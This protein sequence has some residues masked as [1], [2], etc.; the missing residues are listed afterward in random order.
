[1]NFLAFFGSYSF[2]VRESLV[3]VLVAFS[4]YLLL[5]AGIFALPQIGLM[6]VG[7]YTASLCSQG[8][9]TPLLVDVLIGGIAAV[10]VALLLA[11][12]LTR[13]SGIYLAI[14]TIGFGEVVRLIAQNLPLTG[15]PL[16]LVGVDLSINDVEIVGVVVVAVVV[17]ARL[18]RSR[19]GLAMTAMRMDGITA[20]HQGIDVRRYRIILFGGAGFL[21]GIGGGLHAHLTGLIQ[22]DE[23]TFTL[24][25]QIVTVTVIGGMT[26]VAGPLIGAVIIFSLPQVLQPIAP[27]RALIDGAILIVVMAFAPLGIAELL[28]RALGRIRLFRRRAGAPSSGDSQWLRRQEGLSLDVS[29]ISKRFGGLAALSDVTLDVEPGR[30]LGLIGPN[31]SGKTTLLNV[32]S[33]VYV[34]DQG[35]GSLGTADLSRQ[36]GRPTLI[37]REGMSRT[38]QAIRLINGATVRENVRLG[39]YGRSRSAVLPTIL[40]LPSARREEARVDQEIDDCLGALGLLDVANESATALPYGT[41][42]KV[43]IAR[44]LASRP[45]VLLLDEPTAGMTPEERDEIFGLVKTVSGYGIAVVVIEHDVASMTNTC[46]HLVVLDFGR[47]IAQGAPREVI[48]Q[49][50]VIEAYVG[51]RA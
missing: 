49:K 8:L 35:R 17:L 36:W 27:Y 32:L 51:I 41:Q 46:D 26:R 23:F 40:G 44:A 21:A 15:G 2:L 33:G 13:V 9:H 1:M 50:A 34:P 38:F 6:A 47:V 16:G 30:I 45:H 25:I 14:A 22:P 29:G 4:V 48:T 10:I 18:A 5:K 3:Y 19:F 42:R 20:A 11:L 12:L 31:G 43:E 24:L 28:A 39:A 7:G 37:S